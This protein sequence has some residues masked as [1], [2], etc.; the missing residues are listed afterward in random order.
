MTRVTLEVLVS[1]TAGALMAGMVAA[2]ATVLAEPPRDAA[3]EA[4]APKADNPDPFTVCRD[5]GEPVACRR[6]EP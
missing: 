3:I 5:G 4:E 1:T 2:G 6:A